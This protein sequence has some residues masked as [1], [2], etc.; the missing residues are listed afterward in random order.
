MNCCD[1]YS[2]C[3]RGKDCPC[4][5]AMYVVDQQPAPIPPS[6]ARQANEHIRKLEAEKRL[7]AGRAHL[8]TISDAPGNWWDKRGFFGKLATVIG[9]VM[10]CWLVAVL[11]VPR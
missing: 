3:T 11:V 7:E 9:G 6:L 10:A 8:L 1:S 2:T 4:R 5:P